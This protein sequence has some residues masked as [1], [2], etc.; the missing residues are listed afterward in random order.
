MNENEVEAILGQ[1]NQC[2]NELAEYYKTRNIEKAQ[3]EM[4]KAIELFKALLFTTNGLDPEECA[5]DD[6]KAKP[7]NLRERI[8]FISSRPKLYHSYIQLSE[9]FAEQ[10]KQFAKQKALS[11]AKKKRPE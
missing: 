6:C 1:W 4:K 7:V 2:R 11:K 8:D 5:I 3:P 10:E 9:L